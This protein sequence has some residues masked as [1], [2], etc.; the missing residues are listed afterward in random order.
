MVWIGE[1]NENEP[2]LKCRK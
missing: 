1:L 2:L